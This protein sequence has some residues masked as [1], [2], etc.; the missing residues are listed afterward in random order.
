MANL[1]LTSNLIQ[2]PKKQCGEITF[3][4]SD[5]SFLTF[6]KRLGLLLQ[7][8]CQYLNLTAMRPTRTSQSRAARSVLGNR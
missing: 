8:T 2:L 5:F 4:V 6:Q 3:R 1:T 7:G